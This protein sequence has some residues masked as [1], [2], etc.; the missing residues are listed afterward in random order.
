MTW[1]PY[2][3]SVLDLPGAWRNLRDAS[4]FRPSF[5]FVF[6]NSDVSDFLRSTR[7]RIFLI[8]HTVLLGGFDRFQIRY[9]HSERYK[10]S[11]IT[12]G[13]TLS[14]NTIW[15]HNYSPANFIVRFSFFTKYRHRWKNYTYKLYKWV[16]ILTR[17]VKVRR[18]T[19]PGQRPRS[20]R[21]KGSLY[22]GSCPSCDTAHYIVAAARSIVK[23]PRE[24]RV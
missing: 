15:Q 23:R 4:I 13:L 20:Q 19:T 14:S 12:R 18:H 16:L 2:H 6:G 22:W 10:D 1:K 9:F 5:R 11:L 8:L 17:N 24:L 7:S 21:I 3:N